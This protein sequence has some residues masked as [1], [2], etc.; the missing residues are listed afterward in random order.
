MEVN[1]TWFHIPCGKDKG[2]ATR[3]TTPDKE[4]AAARLKVSGWFV[5]GGSFRW[6]FVQVGRGERR[7]LRMGV[8]AR[9]GRRWWCGD[10]ECSV[11]RL[12]VE[13]GGVVAVRLQ[14]GGWQV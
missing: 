10:T 4:A 12:A 6:R 7:M 2:S 9:V 14:R 13:G 3:R 11:A 8:R 1:R 5:E